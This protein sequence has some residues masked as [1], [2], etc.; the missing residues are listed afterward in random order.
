MKREGVDYIVVTHTIPCAALLLKDAKRY[1]LNAKVY[2]TNFLCSEDI[3]RIA[4]PLSKNFYGVHSVSSWY[5]DTPRT[6]EMRKITLKY[7][8]GT[9][10]PWR[11]ENYTV[12]WVVIKVFTEGIKSAGK[13][14]DNEKFV[15]AME[16]FNNYNTQGLSGP[17]TYTSD[18]HQ[19]L[20]YDRIFQ[21]DPEQMKL[22]PVSDWRMA[23][24]SKSKK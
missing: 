21:A 20:N 18:N 11:S 10:K 6:A 12:G 22:I 17:V 4:G 14:I 5:D 23:P 16:T 13:D 19:G 8:P 9:E 3:M 2:G 1:G 15:D 7:R 24:K